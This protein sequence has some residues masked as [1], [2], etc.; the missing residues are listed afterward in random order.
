MRSA[1]SRGQDRGER[2]L[3][4]AFHA[5]ADRLSSASAIR[6][7]E[8]SVSWSELRERVARAAAGLRQIGVRRGDTVALMVEGRPEFMVCDLAVLTIGAVPFSV[9]A[10]S[11]PGQIQ[12]VLADAGARAALVEGAHLEK[13][14]GLRRQLPDLE[15]IV[16]VDPDP[17][18]RTLAELEEC[19]PLD[20]VL[21]AR[22]VRPEDPLTLI[23]TSGTTGEPKGVS[24]THRGILTHTESILDLVPFPANGATVVSWLPAAHIAERGVAYYH[25]VIRGGEVVICTDPRQIVDFLP[26]VRPHWFLAVPRIWEKLQVRALEHLKELGGGEA[27]LDALAADQ[28]LLAELRLRLGLDRATAIHTG[29]APTPPETIEFFL[30]LGVGVSEV[31]GLS[32]TG[33]AVTMNPPQRIKVGTCGPAIP[34][35]ELRLADDGEIL[36]RGPAVMSGYWRRPAETREALDAEGWLATGDVGKLDGD[37]YLTIAGRKKEIIINA[38]GKNMSPMSIEAKVRAASPLIAHCVAIGDARPFNV[39]LIVLD[40]EYLGQAPDRQR[41]VEREVSEAVDAANARMSRVEQIKRF[42]IVADEWAPGGD[43]LTPTSKVKR[44]LALQRYASEIE[45]LYA[46]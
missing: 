46:T 18:R 25:P 39:A 36:V 32:E 7:A 15:E 35:V 16:V 38:A 45:D 42:K 14:D 40:A 5:T 43:L 6:T 11:S 8:R 3:L 34:G 10:T 29:A 4:D 31:Y 41:E 27:T 1:R 9:Y 17:G 30:A 24:L 33:G 28:G 19:E 13:L 2:T 37:G 23:Y 12:Q 26:T 20:D 22:S 44:N 21:A